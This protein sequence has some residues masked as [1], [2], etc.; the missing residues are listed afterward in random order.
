M[1]V[2][3]LV[4]VDQAVIQPLLIRLNFYAPV[5]NVAGRQRMLS[6]KLTKA[7]LA[8]ESAANAD[9]ALAH[10]DE[11]ATAL[12]QWSVAQHGLI[13]GS[14][15]LGIPATGSTNIMAAFERITPHFEAMRDAA[16]SIAMAKRGED[17]SIDSAVRVILDHEP[18]YLPAMDHI[19]GLYE[20]EATR[21]VAWLRLSGFTVMAAMLVL[22]LGVG[23]FVLRPATRTIQ[24]QIRELTLSQRGLS[25]AR[26]EL[27]DRVR[28]RTREL[29]AA[30]S[31]LQC[32]FAE[33]QRVE[34]RNQQ[35]SLQLSHASR[36]TAVGQLATGLAHEINQPLSAIALYAE[37]AEMVLTKD[38]PK[39][40]EA[41]S[42]IARIK[43]SAL[44]AGALVRSLRRFVRSGNPERADV[45]L[46]E[47]IDEVCE[48]CH[49]AVTDANTT[50][51]V[52]VSAELPPACVD[53]IQFQQVLLN[54]IQNS[55]Q[56]MQTGASTHREITISCCVE[57]ELLCLEVAD[58]GP[59]FLCESAE[60]ALQPFF[61]TKK[62]GLGMGLAICRSIIRRHGGELTARNRIAGGASVAFTLPASPQ[63]AYAVAGAIDSLC[64]G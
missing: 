18:Q 57:D 19:V 21:Q 8:M 1:A 20:A 47:L 63:G 26:D 17:A 53:R 64:R 6:Q 4:I 55:V 30:I 34:E 52:D 49:G 38:A 3:L 2:A 46:G 25:Q 27:E 10:R 13:H 11:L 32:E 15:E 29:R 39:L 7:A 24:K 43:Q 50:M 16:R 40:D 23:R 51:R 9:A 22:L 12:A 28:A 61:T 33:R 48:L 35:L 14:A 31:A 62:E 36:I 59:G 56:A 42:A 41:H 5:I 54:L 45:N 58:T 37:T 44:R 60:S